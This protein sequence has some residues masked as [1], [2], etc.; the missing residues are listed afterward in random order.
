MVQ[1]LALYGAIDR[2][3]GFSTLL[4][5]YTRGARVRGRPLAC[6]PRRGHRRPTLTLSTTTASRSRRD[7]LGA[8]LSVCKRP[9]A[10]PSHRF[11]GWTEHLSCCAPMR[12]GRY[13]RVNVHS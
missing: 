12:S 13:H 3:A 2:R 10:R 8:G 1:G 11:P 4:R 9:L 6:E 5:V 7:I